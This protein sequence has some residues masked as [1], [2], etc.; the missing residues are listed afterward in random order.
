MDD[1]TLEIDHVVLAARSR[2]E[3]EGEL[4][5]AGLGVARGRTIP[6]LGL[7]NLIVP[8]NDTQSLEIHY[9]NGESPAPVAPP[10]LEF[11]QQAFAAHPSVP[12]IPMA[13]LVQIDQAARLD[14]LAAANG[15]TVMEVAS[16]GPGLP[17]YSLV[18]FGANFT[19]RYLPA[20]IYWHEGV[21]SLS[22]AHKR[23]P[24]GINQIDVAGPK[25]EIHKW[26]GGIPRGLQTLT[27]TGGPHRVEVGFADGSTCTFGL[28]RN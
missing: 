24:T 28:A 16:E 13:W 4:D 26:C 19:R 9:P 27:G 10:L 7:S 23:R 11:D 14:E 3:A 5:R 22:A 25:D 18:G 6:G 1:T 8:L 17:S 21:P 12:L 15:E 20:L 2:A